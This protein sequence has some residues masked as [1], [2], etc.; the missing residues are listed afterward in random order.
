LYWLDGGDVVE[1]G[2]KSVGDGDG[3]G[4]VDRGGLVGLAVKITTIMPK[5]DAMRATAVKILLILSLED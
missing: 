1:D 3:R 4:S 5:T 2:S